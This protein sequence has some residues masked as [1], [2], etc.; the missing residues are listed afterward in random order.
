MRLRTNLINKLF[1]FCM[2]AFAVSAQAQTGTNNSSD[3]Q[4]QRYELGKGAFS[5]LLPGKPKEEIVSSSPVEG[6]HVDM[7]TY[8]VATEE[9]VYVTQYGLLEAAAETWPEGARESYYSGVWKGMET[10]FNNQ[11]EQSNISARAELVEKRRTKFSGFDGY[12]LTFTL[13]AIRGRVLM[14]LAGRHSFMAMAMGTKDF[15]A[16]DRERFFNSFTIKVTP[17]NIKTTPARPA[18]P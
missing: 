13:G 11:M 10:G 9:G 2:L 5:V 17:A 3:V 18:G 14:T 16:S 7:Y 4:W 1:C 12:E 8:G 6:F 15:P